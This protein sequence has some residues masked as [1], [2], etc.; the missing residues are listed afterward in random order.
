MLH[1]AA[2]GKQRN[3]EIC[4]PGLGLHAL[5]HKLDLPIA[6]LAVEVDAQAVQDGEPLVAVYLILGAAPD[7]SAADVLDAAANRKLAGLVGDNRRDHVR[8]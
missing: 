5:P 3:S 8:Y 1:C 7:L 4:V 2:A 6:V